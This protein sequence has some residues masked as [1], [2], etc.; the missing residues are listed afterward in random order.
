MLG[1][2]SRGTRSS[3]SRC[4]GYWWVEVLADVSRSSPAGVLSISSPTTGD[5][6]GP[7]DRVQRYSILN[8][9]LIDHGTQSISNQT[10]DT[11]TMPLVNSRNDIRFDISSPEGTIRGQTGR[12]N[13]FRG[14]RVDDHDRLLHGRCLRLRLARKKHTTCQTGH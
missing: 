14:C 5:D 1:V 6:P 2:S 12:T 7:G 3:D 4:E 11:P 8:E 13:A 10:T 9:I